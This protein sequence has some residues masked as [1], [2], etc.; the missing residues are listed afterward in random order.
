[1]SSIVW[2]WT[3]SSVQ[4]GSD[5]ACAYNLAR[6]MPLRRPPVRRCSTETRRAAMHRSPAAKQR[7]RVVVLR[8]GALGDALLSFP[9]L[10]LLRARMPDARITFVARADVLPLA[11][12]AHLADAA[13]SFDLPA[14]SALWRTTSAHEPLLS[15]ELDGADM[16]IA[17]LRDAEGIV[18]ASLATRGVKRAVVAPGCPGEEGEPAASTAREH[19]ALYLAHATTS[20]GIG[21]APDCLE[22]L[23]HFTPPLHGALDHAGA[24]ALWDAS[25]LPPS[26]VVALPP[27]SGGAAKCW[28]A[29]SFAALA[30]RLRTAGYHPLLIEGPADG[31]AVAAVMQSLRR[32]SIADP[33]AVARELS[34]ET[35]AAALV[36]CAAFIGNDS[37]VS[38]LA[39]LCAVPT[40]ALFGPTD[41]AVWAPVGS[42]VRVVRAEPPPDAPEARRPHSRMDDLSVEIVWQQLAALLAEARI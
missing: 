2:R 14:W 3:A 4:R 5:G 34:L 37:G 41:P 10:A 13:Y 19:A 31:A 11:L 30:G 42:H 25:R 20:L 12:R 7:P 16:V 29:A 1:M 9:T 21:D 23:S 32:S 27:G 8:P 26:G 24:A 22:Q 36:R 40:L 35:L 6:A 28:P 18:A 17:W 15:A 39:G 38:H 33:P